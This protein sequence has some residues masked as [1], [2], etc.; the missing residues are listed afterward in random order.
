MSTVA[1]DLLNDFGSSGDE[2][3][4]AER[5]GLVLGP[6]NVNGDAMDLDAHE[7]EDEASEGG[8]DEAGE[9]GDA[10]VAK[11]KVEKMEFSSVKDVRSVAGLMQTLRPVLE[12]SPPPSPNGSP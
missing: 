12:V 1:D 9:A 10:E 4:D 8:D 3:E 7:D 2:A 5:D 6:D 11:A